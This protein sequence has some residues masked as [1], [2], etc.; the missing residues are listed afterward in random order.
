MRKGQLGRKCACGEGRGGGRTARVDTSGAEHSLVAPVDTAA[1]DVSL[2]PHRRERGAARVPLYGPDWK[3]C[4]GGSLAVTMK[5]GAG[6]AGGGEAAGTPFVRHSRAP[7]R[8]TVTGHPRP[9][10][11]GWPTAPPQLL[12]PARPPGATFARATPRRPRCAAGDLGCAASCQ[13]CA[14]APLAGGQGEGGGAVG[15][16]GAER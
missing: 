10:Q 4:P 8:P 3:S 15:V 9:R 6:E 2:H 12:A 16:A 1:P 5:G 7:W 14:A 11:R 13:E